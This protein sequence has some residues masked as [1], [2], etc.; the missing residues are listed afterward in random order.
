VAGLNKDGFLANELVQSAVIVQLAVIGALSKRL[1]SEFKAK[2]ALPWKQI[3]GFR[4]RAVH[5]YYQLDL[6]YCV[7]K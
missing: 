1:S 7:T 5:D 2:V 6:D 4:D 3:A